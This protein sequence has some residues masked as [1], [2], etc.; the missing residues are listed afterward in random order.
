MCIYLFIYYNVYDLQYNTTLL[1]V[2][3][4]TYSVACTLISYL[5]RD[6]SVILNCYSTRYKWGD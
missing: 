2:H 3:L 1:S 4:Y 6:S 5:K